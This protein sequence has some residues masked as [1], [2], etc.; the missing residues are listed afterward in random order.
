MTTTPLLKYNLK[1]KEVSMSNNSIPTQEGAKSILLYNHNV[2]STSQPLNIMKV[3]VSLWTAIHA[4]TTRC[5]VF[6]SHNSMLEQNYN[7]RG[8]IVK[9]IVET[10]FTK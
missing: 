7:F 1:Q 5:A 6:P 8:K 4:N 2:S 10:I 9:I 3:L